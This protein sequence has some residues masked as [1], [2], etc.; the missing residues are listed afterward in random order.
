MK[1]LFAL[2]ALTLTLACGYIA[3]TVALADPGQSPDPEVMIQRLIDKLGLEEV[4]A[5][6]VTDT[7]LAAH[8]QGQALQ[9]T[10][11]TEIRALKTGL[12]AGDEQAMIDAMNGLQAIKQD[13]NALQESTVEALQSFLTVEQQAKMTLHHLRKK[14]QKMKARQHKGQRKGQRGTQ[15][16]PRKSR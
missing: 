8:E 4:T 5:Q 7:L 6:D 16:E 14:H 13:K 9:A 15:G 3:N 12:V 1:R 11:K 2:S 10:A